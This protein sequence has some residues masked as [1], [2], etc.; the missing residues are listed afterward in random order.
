MHI[1][2]ALTI[3]F[4]ASWLRSRPCWPYTAERPRFFVRNSQVKNFF[5][6]GCECRFTGEMS[7]AAPFAFDCP[8]SSHTLELDR[9]RGPILRPQVLHTRV[10]RE[11]WLRG[12]SSLGFARM[13][14]DQAMS[15]LWWMLSRGPDQGREHEC[16]GAVGFPS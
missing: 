14:V 16:H 3:D 10:H 6:T 13:R 11:I 15:V 7:P 1:C 2:R 5:S 9:W 4:L 8:H 12:F